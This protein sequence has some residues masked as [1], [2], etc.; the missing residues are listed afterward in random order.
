M[1]LAFALA[2]SYVVA[3]TREIKG[4]IAAE[5]DTTALP[6]VLCRLHSGDMLVQKSV[7]EHPGAFKIATKKNDEVILRFSLAGFSETEILLLR[8]QRIST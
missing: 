6:G 3:Q 1:I 4:L 7:S 8:E 5:N 2:A